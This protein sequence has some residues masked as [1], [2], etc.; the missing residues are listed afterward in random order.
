[1]HKFFFLLV[2][3]NPFQHKRNIMFGTQGQ[4]MLQLTCKYQ[5]HNNVEFK[6]INKNC[7]E[8]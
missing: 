6:C 4:G 1:M 2:R 3:L 8:S 5:N 7:T